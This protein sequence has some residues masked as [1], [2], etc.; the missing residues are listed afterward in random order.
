MLDNLL[1]IVW[2]P[3][4]LT[5]EVG[6]SIDG[7][8]HQTCC[9]IKV[10]YVLH[11]ASETNIDIIVIPFQVWCL[12]HH[13]NDSGYHDRLAAVSLKCEVTVEVTDPS[14]VALVRDPLD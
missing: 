9:S 11:I 6:L 8:G 14:S 4:I 1:S 5:T 2:S 12:I 7:Q 3:S 13:V 10:G